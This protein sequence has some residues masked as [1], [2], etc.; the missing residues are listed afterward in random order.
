[1]KDFEEIGKKMPYRES[2][3]EVDA[4]LSRVTA[5]ALAEAPSKQW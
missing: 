5:R 2:E 1:M 3:E 4:L